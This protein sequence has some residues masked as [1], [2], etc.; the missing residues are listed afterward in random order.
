MMTDIVDKIKDKVP[1]MVM[2]DATTIA[3]ECGNVKSANV[4][5]V[6]ILSSFMGVAPEDVE[7]A[8]ER[9]VPAKALEENLHAFR[10]GRKLHGDVY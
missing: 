10:E 5:L 7:Q 9:L 2:V 4:V 6:G 3:K 8:I 1:Q